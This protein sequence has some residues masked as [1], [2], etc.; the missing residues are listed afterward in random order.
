[1]RKWNS[2]QTGGI[3]FNAQ[4]LARDGTPW[5]EGPM[6]GRWCEASTGEVVEM[7]KEK[8]ERRNSFFFF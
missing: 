3:D 7:V 1:M 5:V 2:L 6:V 8:T 4:T